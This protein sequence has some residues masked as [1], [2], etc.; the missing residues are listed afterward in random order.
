MASRPL[1]LPD[2]FSGEGNWSQWIYHFENVAEVN[3]WEDAK[4]VL[5]L[6]VRLTGRAQIAY[7]QLSDITRANYGDTKKALK[8]RFEPASQTARYLAEFE[9]RRKK[10]TEG[11]ADFAEDL[12]SLV[13]K[14]YPAL[15]EE[16]KA[17]IALSH[18]LRH[19]DQPMT[20]FSTRY[21]MGVRS[22]RGPVAI[23]FFCSLLFTVS[24]REIQLYKVNAIYHSICA[25]DPRSSLPIHNT[26]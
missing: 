14:A 16:A 5:W 2:S 19:L 9:N 6:K 8:E 7:Q 15:Q 23:D 4:R 24:V 17:Q 1:V 26:F 10:K 11:W 13:E 22:F 20:S 18:Y 12:R 3:E 21:P 25:F